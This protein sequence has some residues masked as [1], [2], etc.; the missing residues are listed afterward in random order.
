MNKKDKEWLK[1]I[2]KEHLAHHKITYNRSLDGETYKTSKLFG[3]TE[4][5][6]GGWYCGRR[7]M[8]AKFLDSAET[9]WVRH[10]YQTGE[11]EPDFDTKYMWIPHQCGGCRYFAA[12][13]SDYGICCNEFSPNDGRIT[14]EHGGCI[15]HS[16][17]EEGG[18][19][20]K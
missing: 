8:T 9:R 2:R 1:R 6:E 16:D 13:D 5:S 17:L 14:F 4:I 15:K 7:W 18:V 20:K 11:E 19:L 10:S 12:L 3:D